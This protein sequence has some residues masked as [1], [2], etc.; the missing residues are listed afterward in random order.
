MRARTMIG[1]CVA[2]L[3][4]AATGTALAQGGG[5]GQAKRA[6][7][8]AQR[9]PSRG[10]RPEAARTPERGRGE[11]REEFRDNDR[12]LANNWAHHN[13]ANLPPGLRKQ[14]RLPPGIERQLR[15]GYVI[16]PELREQIHP[17]PEQMVRVF[18][19]APAGFRYVTFGG[20]VVMLDAAF[21]IADII[22]LNVNIGP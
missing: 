16:A 12:E 21:R 7:R 10:A 8:E 13:R 19:P 2:A 3:L 9:Q 11:A 5:R 18:A 14:D 17:A 15:R 20:H 22:R 4:A 6:E 1:V